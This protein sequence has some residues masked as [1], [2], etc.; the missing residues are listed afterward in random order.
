M[1]P[2]ICAAKSRP[3]DYVEG[4]RVAIR[5]GLV[6]LRPEPAYDASIDTQALFGET[7][8]LYE[9]N[10]G[11]GW[12]QMERDSYV[13]YLPITALGEVARPA[14]PSSQSQSDLHLS[15]TEHETAGRR[16][17]AARGHGHA[18]PPQAMSLSASL[19]AFC[20]RRPSRRF[21]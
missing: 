16:R 10:E 6:D 18:S 15:G 14:D 20:L 1:P 4:R 12:I 13:G 21:R 11:W 7:A 5:V 8:V 17:F 9:D 3:A 19:T 2:R